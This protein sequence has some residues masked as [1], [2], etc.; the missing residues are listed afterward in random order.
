MTPSALSP[1]SPPLSLSEQIKGE[2]ISLALLQLSVNNLLLV[3]ENLPAQISQTCFIS[4][5]SDD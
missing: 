2:K 5:L 3:S 1:I 4:F